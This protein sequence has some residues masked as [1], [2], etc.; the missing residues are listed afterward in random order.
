MKPMINSLSILYDLLGDNLGLSIIS[1]TIIIR[2][3]LI[4]LTIRQTKQMKRMQE[5]QPQLQAIQNKYKNKT[6]QNRQKMQQETMALYREAGV[7]PIGCLGPLIIQMPIWIGL[8]RAIF[9]SAPSSPEGYVELSKNFYSWNQ[10]IAKVPFNTEFLGIDLVDFV[11]YAPSPWQFALPVIVGLSMYIQQKFTMSPTTDPRQQQ[12]QQMM[13]WMMPIMFGVFTWQFPAGLAVYI[14][15]SN[16][17]GIFIQY[18]IGGK[19][20]IML[21]GKLYLGTD[22]SRKNYLDKLDD[23]RKSK[24]SKNEEEDTDESKNI[25]RENSRRSNRRSSKNSKRRSRKS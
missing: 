15:F 4:P 18:Y 23:Q 10:S 20:P 17:I 5:I 14:L 13:L 7:N 9:K 12:T 2:F 22:E 21:F 24:T 25:Q 16:I 6:V 19:Q 1:F 11:Q 8:Y 3:I